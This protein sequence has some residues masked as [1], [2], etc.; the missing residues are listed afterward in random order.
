MAGPAQVLH[1]LPRPVRVLLI[2]VLLA[3]LVALVLRAAGVWRH[4]PTDVVL[5]SGILEARTIEVAS[6]VQGVVVSRPIEKGE[7][8]R[9]GQLLA[10]VADPVTAGQFLQAQAAAEAAQRNAQQAQAALDLQLGVSSANV[11]QAQT[12]LGTAGARYRDVQ[13]GSRPQEIAAAEAAVR[14]TTAALGGAQD[15][16]RQLQAGLRPEEIGQAQAAADAAAGQVQVAQAQLADLLAGTR[17]QDLQ[18]AQAAVDKARAAQVKAAHDYDRA[19]EL[20]AQ[21]AISPQAL[22][23]AAAASDAAQADLAAA[24]ERLNL[25]QA[26]ARPDQIQAAR[27]ALSA[28]QAQQRGAQEALV[29]A[30]KGPREEEIARAAEAVRQAQAARDAAGQQ[31]ALVQAGPRAGTRETA[32]RQVSEAQAG[33]TLA[34][35]NEQQVAVRRAALEAAN[36]GYRQALAAANTAHAQLD[37]F[38]IVSEV[39]GLVDDTHVRVGEVLRP[40]SSV[41]TLVDFS[42]TYVTVYV[43]EPYLPRVRLGQRA[44]VTVDGAPGREF[45]GHVRRIAAQAEFTPKNVQTVEERTRTVFAVEIQLP[46][47][48]HVLKPGMPGDARIETGPVASPGGV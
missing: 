4:V 43:P 32:A 33:L 1:K 44:T 14:Q 2:L 45:V 11:Q 24:Q 8:V 40:G 31:L 26:G 23:A 27:A 29:L 28:A 9:Q 13:A 35:A 10:E 16:L 19:R 17:A 15:Q 37:K 20:L 6:E 5:A 46:N 36:A 21:G 42:D 47:E 7:T 41:A 22:D 34:Q 38:R 48:D 25:L 39:D 18:Q 12:A 30:R 3:A